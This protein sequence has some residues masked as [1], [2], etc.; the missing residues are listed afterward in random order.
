MTNLKFHNELYGNLLFWE[1]AIVGTRLRGV[2]L[3]W[4]VIITCYKKAY[5]KKA[6]ANINQTSAN[7]PVFYKYR[8]L[9]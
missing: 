9:P 8:R 6:L 5:Y 7:P 1:H 4:R 3:Q 2:F